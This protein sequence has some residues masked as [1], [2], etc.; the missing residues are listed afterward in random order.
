[1]VVRM[2][3]RMLRDSYKRSRCILEHIFQKGEYSHI[4]S[5]FKMLVYFDD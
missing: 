3:L 2:C 1:M 4:K 5:D